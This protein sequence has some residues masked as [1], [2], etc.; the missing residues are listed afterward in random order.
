MNMPGVTTYGPMMINIDGNGF[1]TTTTTPSWVKSDISH[2]TRRPKP[3]G[4]QLILQPTFYTREDMFET[5]GYSISNVGPHRF[6]RSFVDVS[7]ARLTTAEE[8]DFARFAW[9]NALERLQNNKFDSATFIGE[10]PET[11]RWIANVAKEL[12]DAYQAVK[13]GR[14]VEYLPTRNVVRGRKGR[15]YIRKRGPRYKVVTFTRR[16]GSTYSARLALDGKLAKRYLEWRF[17]VTPIVSEVGSLMDAYYEQALNPIISRV[18]GSYSTNVPIT[19]YFQTGTKRVRTVAIG[20]YSISTSAKALQKWGGINLV[21]T[22]WNLLPLSFMV[23][24]FI[25]IGDFLGNL[26]AEMG[27]TWL[28]YTTSYRNIYETERQYPSSLSYREEKAEG[29]GIIYKRELKKS[30][31]VMPTRLSFDKADFQTGLDTLALLRSILF[32]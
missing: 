18:R 32:K 3:F 27:V 7:M 25:P 21:H 11:I 10:L 2:V 28:A 15:K 1:Q 22:L 13:R 14:W 16:N 26:D 5:R 8:A 12:F 19:G 24:R 29:Y 9:G 4:I 20:Y 30:T 17:A 6:V 31:Q 23:E